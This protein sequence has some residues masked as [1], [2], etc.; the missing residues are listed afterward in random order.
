MEVELPGA[1]FCPCKC[2]LPATLFRAHTS[3]FNLVDV[4]CPEQARFTVR[5]CPCTGSASCQLASWRLC[6][7][8]MFQP[9]VHLRLI[10]ECFQHLCLSVYLSLCLF[11][12]LY[13]SVSLALPMSFCLCGFLYDSL[14]VFLSLSFS[15]S[16]FLC[17][18]M[19]L[20]VYLLIP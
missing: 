19:S 3:F 13:A 7:W 11:L 5:E 18:S 4:R 2:P 12:S 6:C 1:H 16:P 20:T 17:V 9:L 10:Y 15:F 14:S 8:K